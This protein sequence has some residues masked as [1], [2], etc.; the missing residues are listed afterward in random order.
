M[1][2]FARSWGERLARDARSDEARIE[3][4][5]HAAF[6]RA[7]RADEVALARVFLADERAAAGAEVEPAARESAAFTALAHVLFASKEFIYL[8]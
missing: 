1:H 6:G 3:S 7:P 8:R 2:E 4:A 5:W